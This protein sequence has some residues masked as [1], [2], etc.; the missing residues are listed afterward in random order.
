MIFLTINTKII[1]FTQKGLFKDASW[2]LI[3][4]LIN[5][6][7]QAAYFVIVARALG[8]ENYGS[9][10]GITSLASLLF[11]FITLGS[12][13]VL[14]KEVAVNR[15]VFYSHWGNTLL[16]LVIN[17]IVITSILL[18]ISPLIF[19]SRISLLTINFLL[20]AD[21]FCLGLL[22]AC[23][24]AFRA[25]NLMPKTAQLVIL[26]TLGKLIAALCLITFFEQTNSSERHVA[27]EIWAILY[28]ISSI[29]TGLCAVLAV[30]Q[31]VG[32]PTLKLSRIGSDIRQGIYFSIG[33]SASNI[34][35]N[36]D[37][38]MLAGMA[39]LEATGIY[40]SAY[41]F[42][43]IGH[44]PTAALFNATY[45][46][47]FQHGAKGIKN[48]FKFAKKLLPLIIGY[49]IVSFITY[50][51]FA[52]LIPRILGAEYQN[53]VSTLCWLAP[54]P[55]ITALQLVAADTLTG[56]GY[57]KV[58]SVVQVLAAI[59]NVI[60]NIWLIPIFGL[61]GAIWATLCSDGLRLICLW[62]IVFY[63]YNAQNQ[64]FAEKN[65]L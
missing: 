16:I 22:E 53:A 52:P 14:V 25:V 26:N 36:I 17:S 4:R 18:L 30:N 19:P 10:I 34:N 32:K 5:V 62:I 45:P 11:P 64:S 21:L 63:L 6:I 29:A 47:F 54:L 60:M 43:N 37:K 28:F 12:D 1:N 13:N 61:M 7:V 35:S 44:V 49:G 23:N 57:Q 27:I 59:V 2:M 65:S 56:S 3:A 48:C 55:A 40:G 9:F 24:K 42:I 33:M 8:A 41:R 58:R 39:T 51:I 15:Q 50:Q 20:L 31:I 46:R 38:T